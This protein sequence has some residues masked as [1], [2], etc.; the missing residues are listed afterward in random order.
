MGG[1]KTKATVILRLP[2][3]RFPQQSYAAVLN[4][5]R[6]RLVQDEEQAFLLKRDPMTL[7]PW[8]PRKLRVGFNPTHPLMVLSA[9]LGA[10]AIKAAA[11]ARLTGSSLTMTVRN[12]KFGRYHMTGTRKMVARRWLGI[13]RRTREALVRRLKAEG[14]RI[15]RTRRPT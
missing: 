5:M 12:P 6:P 2:N 14:L 3:G 4:D 11:D 13:S 7:K 15:F 1:I 9:K 10:A 8:A